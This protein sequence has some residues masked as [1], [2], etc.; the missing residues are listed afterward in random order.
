MEIKPDDNT[1]KEALSS[2]EKAVEWKNNPT[3]HLIQDEVLLNSDHYD[4]SP[5]WGDKK[6]NVLI[7]ASAREG[8]TGSEIDARTG[9]ALWI[10]GQQLVI[11]MGNGVSHSC[12][13]IKLI[14]KMLTKVLP[15]FLQK[16]MKSSSRGV[17]QNQS[18]TWVV[19]FFMLK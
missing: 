3:K 18:L 2:C 17:L 4:Y 5:A 19:R 6:H 14:Q 1:A 12:Y 9:K 16:E 13:L 15:F 7:F 8:S 10:Y 11:T